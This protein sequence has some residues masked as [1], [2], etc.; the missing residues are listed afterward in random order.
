MSKPFISVLIDTFNH[1][2][3]IE[4]AISSVLAQDFPASHREILVVDDGSTDRTPEILAKFGSQIQVLRKSNGGQASAFN[5]GIPR[6]RGEVIAFL[7]GDDWWAKTKLS[8]VAEILVADHDVILV[9][10]GI[11]EAFANGQNKYIV[12]ERRA[13]LHINS[14]S[15]ASSFRLHKAYLGTSRMTMRAEVARRLLPVPESLIIEADEYLF[16]V[17]A[18]LGEVVILED[19]LTFYRIHD[20]N[21]YISSRTHSDVRRKQRSLA[22]LAIALRQELSRNSVPD[23]AVSCIVEIIQAEADQL[24]LSLGQGSRWETLQT[25]NKLFAVLHHNAPLLPRL[26]RTVSMCAALILPPKWFYRGRQWLNSQSCYL[27]MRREF[28]PVPKM[29]RPVGPEERY[30][31]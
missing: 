6:C 17:A 3:F 9:G 28:L 19:A 2:R 21:L 23:D 5:T 14:L 4:E 1:E 10:S 27:R 15:H 22:A 16:T 25:E 8:R 30:E 20:G 7:D 18:A 24:R 29:T 26:F 12:P 31:S 13:R 11:I